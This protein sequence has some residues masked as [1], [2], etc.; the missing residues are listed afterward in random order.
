MKDGVFTYGLLY[1]P[2]AP[3]CKKGQSITSSRKRFH[4]VYFIKICHLKIYHLRHSSNRLPLQS[5]N[6]VIIQRDS[7][8]FSM[9]YL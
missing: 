7:L 6:S 1:L 9:M 4:D 3:L 2:E 8:P 5:Q